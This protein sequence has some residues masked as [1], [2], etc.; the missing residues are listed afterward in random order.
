M[1]ETPNLE[2][3]DQA[4]D[5]LGVCDQSFEDPSDY[6]EGTG[7]DAI[8]ACLIHEFSE[9]E[10]ELETAHLQELDNVAME[11]E[12]NRLHGINVLEEVPGPLPEHRKLSTRFV[13][14]WRP[15]MLHGSMCWLRR[16]R[17]VAR[18]FAFLDPHRENLYSPASNALQSR[19]IPSVFMNNRHRGWVMC[20]LDVADA[21]FQC[22]Q[23]E[24][25]CTSVSLGG[26][27]VWFRLIKCLPGQRDGS[28]KW[29][30]TFS[31]TLKADAKAELMPELPSLFR[32]P[33]LSEQE[34]SPDAGGLL[35]VDDM[36]S[37]G[38]KQTLE[39]VVSMLKGRFK[40]SVEWII[41]VGDELDFLKKRHFLLSETELIIQINSKHLDKLRELTGNPKTRKS[42]LPSGVLSVEKASDTA[43]DPERCTLCRQAVGVLLYMQADEPASQF[44]IRLLATYMS[45]P[46]QGAWS[47]LRHLVGYLTFTNGHCVCLEAKGIGQGIK[48]Q[49]PGVNII[50]GYSDSDWAG[51]RK[52]RK[53]VSAAAICVNGH[54]IYGASRTQKVISLSSAEAEFH[55]AVSC[56]IDCIL[57]KAM[58]VF[59]SPQ[60][61]GVPHVL[62]D[63]SA[64]RAILQRSGVGR[65]RHLDA[66]L[67]WAQQKVKDGQLIIN[68]VDTKWNV[69]DLG[70]K[71]LNVARTNLLLSLLNVRDSTQGFE[72]VGKEQL[73]V[74][75]NAKAVRVA[76]KQLR[77]VSKRDRT[78]D[79]AR[80]LSIV[81]CALQAQEA[82]G[83]DND[84]DALS[85]A[86]DDDE[87][88][89]FLMQMMELV[90]QAFFFMTELYEQ[91]PVPFLIISQ[92]L[93]ISILMI[94]VFVCRRTPTERLS[95]VHS[96]RASASANRDGSIELSIDAG[97]NE[98]SSGSRSRPEPAYPSD[99]HPSASRVD[100]TEVVH[101]KAQAKA[102]PKAKAKGK[103]KAKSQSSPISPEVEARLHEWMMQNIA[104]PARQ[105][106]ASTDAHAGTNTGPAETSASS[107]ALPSMPREE[108]VYIT[109]RTGR[110]YHKRRSCVGLNQAD[111]IQHVG[112]AE[113]ERR[114]KVPCNVCFRSASDPCICS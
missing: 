49:T 84:T 28:S 37:T 50:E 70:T 39:S 76:C 105:A 62:V 69:S 81:L 3:D 26:R 16:A 72:L 114:G 45:S 36:L 93:V 94:C 5:E 68:A 63:N 65:V 19:V 9:R 20:A 27:V 91:Y 97:L 57:V 112:L 98:G 41:N 86:M 87:P 54:F 75:E 108:H 95:R 59:L 104:I 92:T 80:I 110:K 15:K 30:T 42:P 18:E 79:T 113:A 109:E 24:P 44:A 14:T 29:F 35:H 107:Q 61:T 71:V 106:A 85:P 6:E 31:E 83:T 67:L 1:D 22:D 4:F 48:V 78:G 53:S 82:M 10:P 90:L 52:S 51:D 99:T 56:S 103:A 55:S 34:L 8:P 47:L 11:Y 38:K 25:T 46:T 89:S 102:K 58:F 96:I 60:P 21:Y 88:T 13:T 43:V 17:L 2:F 111:E 100:S 40:I 64:A 12:V 33:S 73:D 77:H 7:D 74:L 101:P 66:K 23:G 32:I